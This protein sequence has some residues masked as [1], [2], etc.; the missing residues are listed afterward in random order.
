MIPQSFIND[1]IERVDIAD[2]IGERLSLKRTGK[3]LKA[4]CPFHNEKTESFT[5]NSDKQFYY[6]FGCGATGTSL[7]FLMEHDKL[8]FVEA[9]ETLA[10]IAGVEVVHEGPTPSRKIDPG[11][12]DALAKADALFQSNLRDHSQSSRAIEY[13]KGR[14]VSGLVARD[15]GIGYAPDSWDSLKTALKKF[16]NKTL[17]DAGLLVLNEKGRLYDRF[18]HRIQF[19]I[20][21]TRGRVIGFGGRVLGEGSPKYLNSPESEVFHKNKELYGL[22]EARR[23]NQELNRLILVEG[24]MDVIALAQAGVTNAVATLGTATSQRHFE[25]LF[26]RTNEVVCCFDGDKAGRSAAW[27]SLSSAFPTL[28]GG[29]ILK[30]AFLPEGEDPDTLI[31]RDRAQFV[32][33]TNTAV[34]AGDYFFNEISK[35]LD[36]TS[37]DARARLAELAIPFLE[38]VPVGLYR[39]MMIERLG[40]EAGVSI[41]TIERK[42]GEG[43]P[44]L[45]A[46]IKS[47]SVE[48]G[49]VRNVATLILNY[50]DLVRGLDKERITKISNIASSHSSIIDVLINYISVQEICDTSTLLAG[51]IG[52]K[53][54]QLLRSLVGK[55]PNLPLDL[56]QNDLEE[57]IDRYLSDLDRSGGKE[58]LEDLKQD[59]SEENLARYLLAKKN[60]SL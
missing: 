28:N 10:R 12:L 32:R 21:D 54:E 56:L 1:L 6:C 14:G 53:Y 15:F 3:N 27:K 17:V 40:R 30:F 20:R 18:R 55:S 22:F 42:L 33:L 59:P 38:K 60:Q 11:I 2:V 50:P 44:E 9:V 13:L 58:R 23:A 36:L 5:V 4:L 46:E 49:L 24:Y 16:P 8:D 37:L 43:I 39:T 57:G 19:P 7:R 35:D 47:Q 45:R 41:S 51:F 52:N 26:Q 31:R 48:S 25:K 34:A 29:R